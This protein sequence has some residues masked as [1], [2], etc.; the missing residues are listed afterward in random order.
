MPRHPDFEKIYQHFLKN[1]GERGEEVYYRWLKKLGYDDTKPLEG[2]R[3]EEGFNWMGTVEAPRENLVKGEALHPV[4]TYHPEEWPEVRVYL[5]EELAKSAETLMGKPLLLDHY[6]VLPPPNRVVYAAYGDGGLEYVA[7]VDDEVARMVRDGLIRHCSVEFDWERLERL[8]GVAP[9]GIE[10]TGLSLLKD[11]EPGDPRTTVELWEGILR[12]LRGEEKMVAQ[13]MQTERPTLHERIWTKRYINDLPDSAFAVIEHGGKKDEEGKTVPRSLRHLHHHNASG[14][15]DKPHLRSANS[16]V[17][18][19]TNL[20][21]ELRRK[22]L[23]HLD[24]HKRKLGIGAHAEESETPLEGGGV[25]DELP[26]WI[27]EIIWDIES[28]IQ[29]IEEE[30][31]E[32]KGRAEALEQAETH[33]KMNGVEGRV[34]DEGVIERNPVAEA[35]TEKIGLIDEVLEMLPESVPPGVGYF[36]TELVHRLRRN[37]LEKKKSSAEQRWRNSEKGGMDRR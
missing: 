34:L 19:M 7:E 11:I 6:L 26:T 5:E 24:A 12:H 23:E 8:D 13:E 30:V 27:D 37:L 31:V 2:Q 4:K 1:Y 17:G 35:P 14:A 18:Q 28:A 10:F 25:G 15:V 21:E 16:R 9:R 36:S 22:A 29:G 3:G 33:P 32:L 20:R